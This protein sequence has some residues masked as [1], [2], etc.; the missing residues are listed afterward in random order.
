MS[1]TISDSLEIN[2]MSTGCISSCGVHPGQILLKCL[3][4]NAASVIASHGHPSDVSAEPSKADISISIKL[5]QVLSTLDISFLDH[6]VAT[7][8]KAISLAE[9]GDI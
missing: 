3:R 2:T 9:R 8:G 1:K 4:L 7:D 6:I 5:R